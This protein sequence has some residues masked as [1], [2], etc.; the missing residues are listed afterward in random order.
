MYLTQQ[1][2]ARVRALVRSASFEDL[3]GSEELTLVHV[4]DIWIAT[5]NDDDGPSVG[6][7]VKMFEGHPFVAAGRE[8]DDLRTDIASALG[9][10]PIGIEGL[11][12]F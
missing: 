4:G 12:Q 3:S 11:S 9:T 6:L 5:W 1:Q 10:E 7:A 2:R 8:I